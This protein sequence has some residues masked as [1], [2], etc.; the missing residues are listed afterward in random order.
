M[1]ELEGLTEKAQEKYREA[2]ELDGGRTFVSRALSPLPPGRGRDPDPDAPPAG[3][4]GEIPSFAGGAGVATRFSWSGGEREAGPGPESA[5]VSELRLGRTTV[6]PSAEDRTVGGV[7]VSSSETMQSPEE[8][9]FRQAR[10]LTDRV[11]A[12]VDQNVYVGVFLLVLCGVLWFAS[13]L[14]DRGRSGTR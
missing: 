10:E 6:V 2:R 8:T 14:A 11:P 7:E 1:Y 12:R 4:P 5:R 3:P 13:E 9:V